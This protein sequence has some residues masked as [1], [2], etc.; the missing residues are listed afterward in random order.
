MSTEVFKITEAEMKTIKKVLDMISENIVEQQSKTWPQ[1]GDDC[2]ELDSDGSIYRYTYKSTDGMHKLLIRGNLYKTEEEA[3]A[4][5]RQRIAETKVIRRLRELEPEGWKPKFGENLHNY[6]PKY[7][8]YYDEITIVSSQNYL[9]SNVSW[10][11]SQ[12]AWLRVLEEMPEAIKTMLG[13]E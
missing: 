1:D 10:L 6:Y 4:A 12:N 3:Q 11:S 7:D 5:D 8:S 2:Y 9:L 13:V